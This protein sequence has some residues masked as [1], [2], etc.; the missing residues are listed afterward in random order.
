MQCPNCDLTDT[1]EAFGKPATCP[2]CG[3]I[4]AKALRVRAIR[5]EQKLL[6][7]QKAE[8]DAAKVAK[9]EARAAKIEAA[10]AK[11]ESIRKQGESKISKAL[12]GAAAGAAEARQAR[13]QQEAGNIL[14]TA[15][16]KP[17]AVR[18]ES[19][20]GGCF[21]VVMLAIGFIMFATIVG[22]AVDSYSDYKER[23]L[24]PEA[25]A[26]LAQSRAKERAERAKRDREI[27]AK[28]NAEK[29]VKNDLLD[30]SAAK[31]RNQNKTCGEVNSKNIFGAYTGFKRY[32][33]VSRDLYFLDDDSSDFEELWI[34]L[35]L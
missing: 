30:P 31:F 35:C 25:A 33:V 3:A 29:I 12:G 11:A 28:Y 14:Y 5:N 15:D 20:N 10:K 32:L 17:V 4:Y 6:R 8:D 23:S 7:Q 13:S 16:G 26:E 22:K 2:S 18:Q 34:R 21:G 24:D 1:D 9:A 27:N 19:R